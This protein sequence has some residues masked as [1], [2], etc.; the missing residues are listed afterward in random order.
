MEIENDNE[1]NINENNNEKNALNE[2]VYQIGDGMNWGYE[3]KQQEE[4]AQLAVYLLNLVEE[5]GVLK[6]TQAL[7]R[8]VGETFTRRPEMKNLIVEKVFDCIEWTEDLTTLKKIAVI[9]KVFSTTDFGSMITMKIMD[10]LGGLWYNVKLVKERFVYQCLGAIIASEWCETKYVP[11]LF[12]WLR[13]TYELVGEAERKHIKTEEALDIEDEEQLQ[14][15]GK[16]VVLRIVEQIIKLKRKDINNRIGLFQ[17]I[18]EMRDDEE[19]EKIIEEWDKEEEKLPFDLPLLE[20]KNVPMIKTFNPR[21]KDY[22]VQKQL[23]EVKKK[24]KKEERKAAK[25]EENITKEVMDM[26]RHQEEIEREKQKKA[27]GK[28]LNELQT[29]QNEWKKFDKRKAKQNYKK[30]VKF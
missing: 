22:D 6:I 3:I 27:Y 28:I 13:E 14:A 20:K 5:F 21:F 17:L 11:E 4:F 12:G 7:Q 24:I 25:I 10:Y 30:K 29:Q 18:D 8:Y 23:R 2:V 26:K 1:N 19:C 15:Y 16:D 9:T